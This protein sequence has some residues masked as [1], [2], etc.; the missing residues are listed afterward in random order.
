M[1]AEIVNRTVKLYFIT[2]NLDD[3]AKSTNIKNQNTN[4]FTQ[5]YRTTCSES[6]LRTHSIYYTYRYIY[7]YI[8]ILYVSYTVRRILIFIYYIL[9]YNNIYRI[10]EG[11]IKHYISESDKTNFVRGPMISKIVSGVSS[12]LN[13]SSRDSPLKESRPFLPYRQSVSL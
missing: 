6:A 11:G 9:R 3:P 1:S 13:N 7:I 5:M 10:Y 12:N 8:Y 2:W 4:H